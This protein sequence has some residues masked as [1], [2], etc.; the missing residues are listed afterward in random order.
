M[1]HECDQSRDDSRA[2]A[3]LYGQLQLF[4]QSF[5]S[6]HASL[7]RLSQTLEEERE[8]ARDTLS[9]LRQELSAVERVAA[10]IRRLSAKT[11]ETAS[12]VDELNDRA[13]Q[14]GGIVGLIRDVAEQTNL[15]AL[16]AAIEAARAG[17]Q[18]RGF[19]VVA[20]E[21]RRL[22]ERTA[23]A[24]GQITSLVSAIQAEVLQVKERVA[25]SPGEAVQF[26]NDSQALMDNMHGI[27]ALSE[28][29]AKAIE[30]SALRSFTETAKVDHLN[31][32]FDIYKVFM[33]LS[34]SGAA[35]FAS[36]TACRL[37]KWYYEGD[38]RECCSRLPGYRE[39]EG[40]HEAVHRYGVEAINL[41]RS[42]KWAQG[43]AA[44]E[45]MEKASMRVLEE[46]ER[47]AE[48][49]DRNETPL[50]PEQKG[51][52]HQPGE[53]MPLPMA[54]RLRRERANPRIGRETL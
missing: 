36:H 6:V 23:E 50:S 3:Q 29:M 12:R 7:A 37:G 20:D 33:G 41:Y 21:V 10:N 15:L 18:G 1:R 14:I 53:I 44:I 39:L 16:N 25:L 9:S 32:K 35:D 5:E 2:S 40:P 51:A 43:V 52:T 27:M 38:G 34:D 17:E 19:A 30:G 26:A 28:R 45:T 48:G 11:S 22:A 47:L 4:G 46:L 13:A 8:C 31:F 54:A 24:T 42:G 49:G